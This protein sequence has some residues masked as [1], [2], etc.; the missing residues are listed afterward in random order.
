MKTTLKI[1]DMFKQNNGFI[2][3]TFEMMTLTFVTQKNKKM[4]IQTLCH[5]RVKIKIKK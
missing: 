4:W 2:S 3:W 1:M 5:N